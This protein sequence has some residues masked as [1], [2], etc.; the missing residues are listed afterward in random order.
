MWVSKK[1]RYGLRMLVELALNYGELITLKEI[2]KREGISNKYLEQIVSALRE[3]K[4]VEAERGPKGGYR[5]IK[6]PKQIT[7]LDVFNIFEG[8]S[9]I[10]ECLNDPLLCERSKSCKSRSI[11]CV[12]DRK[13]NETLKSIRL[14]E[15]V[16]QFNKN[17]GVQKN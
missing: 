16:K 14:T 1:T 8:H 13:I 5:L 15:I 11:W 4:Y 2:S 3:A 10:V 17:K 7:L 12:A 9:A 6:D